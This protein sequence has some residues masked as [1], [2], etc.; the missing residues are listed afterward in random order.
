MEQKPPDSKK[1]PAAFRPVGDRKNSRTADPDSLFWHQFAEATTPR[2]FC[3]SWLPLQCRMIKRVRCAMVLLG[4]PDK[5]PFT[6]V[7]VWPDAKL[8]IHHLTG[9]AERSLKERRGL[10]VEKDSDP[11]SPNH[12]PE[13]IHIAYPIEVDGKLH[14]TVVLGVDETDRKVIQA[15]MRRLH[16]GAA[17]LEVLIRRTQAA[18]SEAVSRRLQKARAWRHGQP[19]RSVP[20]RSLYSWPR[21]S[22][23]TSCRRC[24]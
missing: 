6:P 24:C 16:W 9:A 11:A 19:R 13:N 18:T 22:S 4:E 3:Q 12:F 2:A 23:A 20:R 10:L 17:W 8:S 7:A 21:A 14:G 1:D 15:I 5:G